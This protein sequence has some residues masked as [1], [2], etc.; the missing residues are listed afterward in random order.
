MPGT[1]RELSPS[2]RT[3]ERRWEL[4]V[5]IGRDPARTVRDDAGRVI[6]QGPPV[7]RSKVFT[8]GKRAAQRALEEFVKDVREEEAGAV[9]GTGATVGR[10]L[11][12]WMARYV[13]RHRARATIETYKVH[14]DKHIRPAL[15]KIRLSQLTAYDVDGYLQALEA[16]G[17]SAG[18]IKL[19]YS[20]LSGA[21]SQA[22]SWGW[23]KTNPAKN[24]RVR[25]AVKTDAPVLNVGALR[26]LYWAAAED[27]PD[28]AM[29]IA[30]A[31]LTG[32]RRG[33]LCG[34]QW[35]DVDWD[36][37]CLKVTRAWVPGAG[38]QHLTT[39]KTGKGRTV[40]VGAEGAALLSRYYDA[41]RDLLGHDP[42]PVGW[43]LS[44]D[45]GV[46]PMRAKTLTEYVTKLGRKTGI[47]V[48]V[49]SLRHF[50]S[51]ALKI[52]DVAPDASFDTV[53]DR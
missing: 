50:A 52:G 32:C 12:E 11:D 43:L 49:H 28:M 9:V 2:K 21:L 4:R 14:V 33:E 38:G 6:Q 45:G 1:M 34:L 15:G 22:V 29:T 8:G 40:F 16:K 26:D 46:T 27:D 18:T 41:K 35:G 10:L 53:R 36:R 39:T 44:L 47:K 5:F 31:A 48:H 17:L 3:G 20:I 23:I 42:A 30:L 7:H 19:D 25:A 13:E 37:Q 51:T 24:A